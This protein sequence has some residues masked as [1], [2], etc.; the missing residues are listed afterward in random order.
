M[1]MPKSSVIKKQGT[2]FGIQNLEKN[3]PDMHLFLSGKIEK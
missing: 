2:S 1:A 3:Y